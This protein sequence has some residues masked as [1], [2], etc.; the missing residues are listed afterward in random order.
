[1]PPTQIHQQKSSSDWFSLM[2]FFG[3]TWA[4]FFHLLTPNSDWL[5]LVTSICV[6]ALFLPKMGWCVCVAAPFQQSVNFTWTQLQSSNSVHEQLN[7][8]STA[9]RVYFLRLGL[10]H[11]ASFVNMG[12]ICVSGWRS[13]RRNTFDDLSLSH[14]HLKHFLYP[15]SMVSLKYVSFYLKTPLHPTNLPLRSRSITSFSYPPKSDQPTKYAPPPSHTPTL[16]PFMH[17]TSTLFP[18]PNLPSNS[19]ICQSWPLPLNLP[20]QYYHSL[21]TKFILHSSSYLVSGSTANTLFYPAKTGR[22]PFLSQHVPFIF[23]KSAPPLCD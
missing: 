8:C 2:F 11:T 20:P 7:V 17:K 9:V 1:M 18:P 22:L 13:F 19:V 4:L 5:L 16:L 12:F 14:T 3:R 10:K 23:S 15:K 6:T 21:L